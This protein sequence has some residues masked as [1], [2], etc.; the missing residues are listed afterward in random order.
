VRT[1][2]VPSPASFELRSR[3]TESFQEPYE[4]LLELQP[5]RLSARQAGQPVPSTKIREFAL[6]LFRMCSLWEHL[7][8]IVLTITITVGMVPRQ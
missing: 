7:M 8:T 5:S 2:S 4:Q 1:S 3:M 6:F